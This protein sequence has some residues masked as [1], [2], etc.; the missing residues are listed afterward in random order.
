MT[1][2]KDISIL[3]LKAILSAKSHGELR[4]QDLRQQCER[5]CANHSMKESQIQNIQDAVKHTEEQW[6]NVL[7]AAEEAYNLAENEASSEKKFDAFKEQNETFQSWMREQKQ[8]LMGVGGQMQFEER[9]QTVQVG[10]AVRI[11]Y[12]L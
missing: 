11:S 2:Y 6:W 9:L 1:D 7:K 3:S 8:K 10:S 4:L 5:L 12:G